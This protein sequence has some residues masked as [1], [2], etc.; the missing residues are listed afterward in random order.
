MSLAEKIY[1]QQVKPLP[2]VERLRLARLIVDG[3]SGSASHWAVQEADEW[4]SEDLSDLSRA[5]LLYA[6]Q[7]LTDEDDSDVKSR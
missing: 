5:S 6:V 4:S 2:V 3:L 1:Q 7:Q